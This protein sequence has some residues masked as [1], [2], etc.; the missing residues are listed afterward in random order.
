M[1]DLVRRILSDD[2]DERMPPPSSNKSLTAEQKKLLQ[3]WIE[4]GAKYDP[5][6][7]FV[8]P[9]R[10]ELPKVKQTDWPQNEIDY[11]VLAKLEAAGL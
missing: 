5:H 3:T 6:W 7:A 2:A 1:S 11:F 4:Q 8:P 10:P 9:R